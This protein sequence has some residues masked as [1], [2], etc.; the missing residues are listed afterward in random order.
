MTPETNPQ[1]KIGRLLK[2]YRT[3]HDIGQRALAREIGL[4]A[5]TI[6]RVENGMKPDCDTTIKL[7]D[8][9]FK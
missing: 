8:W 9:M 4:S 2:V 3:I 7:I 1:I 6:C 5:P